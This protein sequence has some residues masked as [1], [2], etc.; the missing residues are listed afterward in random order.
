MGTRCHIAPC[1]RSKS[2]TP[3]DKD[4]HVA[5]I[6]SPHSDESPLFVAKDFTE[7]QVLRIEPYIHDKAKQCHSLNRVFILYVLCPAL[8]K[9]QLRGFELR[10]P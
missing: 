3:S 9:K 10:E 1:N 6:H 2:L 7:S 4:G 5:F 8:V